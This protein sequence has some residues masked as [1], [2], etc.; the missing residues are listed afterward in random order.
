MRSSK[1][2]FAFSTMAFTCLSSVTSVDT[3]SARRPRARTCSATSSSA[4]MSR[5]VSNTSAPSRA[6][7]SVIAAPMPLA[8][9]V[10]MACLFSSFMRISS[11]GQIS[12]LSLQILN[13]SLFNY[14]LLTGTP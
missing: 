14:F 12:N 11:Q 8:A 4:P 7:V 5:A 3:V 6:S 2:A 9:P 13:L 1:N 10:T